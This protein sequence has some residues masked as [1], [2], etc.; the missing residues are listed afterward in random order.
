MVT[1]AARREAVALVR[2][3]LEVSERRACTMIG[4]CRMT[5]RY[6]S[7]RPDD[8]QLRER[9]KTLADERRRFGYRRLHVLL[10]REGY[11]VNHKRLFRLYREEKLTVRRRGGRD[12]GDEGSEKMEAT[13]DLLS[14]APPAAGAWAML[15]AQRL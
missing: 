3:K 14:R 8:R 12:D 5:V 4:I 2:E 1:P 10:R 11:V 13:A 6:R 7:Q 9:M 15:A